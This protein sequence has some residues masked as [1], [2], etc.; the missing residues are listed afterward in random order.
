MTAEFWAKLDLLLDFGNLFLYAPRELRSK[1]SLRSR[2][3][4]AHGQ[5][6]GPVGLWGHEQGGA[7]LVPS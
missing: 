4:V 7:N 2:V 1:T 5:T 3:V 6:A